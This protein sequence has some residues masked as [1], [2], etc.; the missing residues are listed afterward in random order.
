MDAHEEKRRLLEPQHDAL[1]AAMRVQATAPEVTVYDSRP[2]YVTESEVPY[3]VLVAPPRRHAPQPPAQ[4]PVPI[5]MGEL[6]ALISNSVTLQQVKRMRD[7]VL[8]AELGDP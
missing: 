5:A 1:R 3:A 8:D 7:G 4:P 6:G 2:A